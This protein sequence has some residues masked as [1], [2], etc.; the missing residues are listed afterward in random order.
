MID[1]ILNPN[2][3]QESESFMSLQVK[4]TCNIYLNGFCQLASPT[5]SSR[6]K[7]LAF[8]KVASYFLTA[9]ILALAFLIVREINNSLIGRSIRPIEPNKG[10]LRPDSQKQTSK[11]TRAATRVIAGNK[12]VDEKQVVR[13]EPKNVEKEQAAKRDPY[14]TI[15]NGD[16]KK[17]EGPLVSVP[18]NK[19]GQFPQKFHQKISIDNPKHWLPLSKEK[20]QNLG[21]PEYVDRLPIH[22][23]NSDLN[24]ILSLPSI[25]EYVKMFW[26][27][28]KDS[29]ERLYSLKTG[30][31]DIDDI[32]FQN[33]ALEMLSP[34]GLLAGKTYGEIAH[35]LTRPWECTELFG[36]NKNDKQHTL[37][38]TILIRARNNAISSRL[39]VHPEGRFFTTEEIN[40]GF[41]RQCYEQKKAEWNSL[42]IF[43][44]FD[45]ETGN[46]RD[47]INLNELLQLPECPHMPQI[48]VTQQTTQKAVESLALEFQDETDQ[49]CWLNLA[50]AHMDGG[51]LKGPSR[52]GDTNH[53]S[54]EENTVSDCSAAVIQA[55]V[56]KIVQ[57]EG[58]DD[59]RARYKYGFHIPPGGNFFMKTSFVT[60]DRVKCSSIACA[61]ADFRNDPS[62][63]GFSEFKNYGADG[64]LRVDDKYKKRIFMDMYG[65]LATAKAKGQLHLVLG[66][67]GCGAFKHDRMTEAQMWKSVL[68]MP[69]FQG[70]FKTVTFAITGKELAGLFRG[71]LSN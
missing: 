6:E 58:N 19:K 53:G 25:Q 54:Q 69:E 59:G 21:L 42:E 20:A 14:S 18:T 56:S 3:H 62:H 12:N 41:M 66:A 71:A 5:A 9:G 48:R 1:L 7:G 16:L 38:I 52:V 45:W 68:A 29:N 49:L 13:R 50:N 2:L 31:F 27:M 4:N 64:K 44:W 30:Y 33:F 61:F 28:D 40:S 32:A 51:I 23:R 26:T 47:E 70:C 35:Q 63:I 46:L 36:F 65:V 43:S 10:S 8:L 39:D 57:G 67:S 15:G 55:S 34:K 37:P 24:Y 60:G 11:A 17:I 22:L